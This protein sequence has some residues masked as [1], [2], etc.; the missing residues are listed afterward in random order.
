LAYKPELPE[1]VTLPDGH[2]VDVSHPSYKA[3]E[4][5]A[6]EERWT[7]KSFSRAGRADRPAL[8]GGRSAARLQGLASS[9]KRL[10]PPHPFV[11]A[12][13]ATIVAALA[14]A[15]VLLVV[16]F[17]ANARAAE[18]SGPSP[19]SSAGPGQY[20]VSLSAVTSLSVPEFAVSATICV[21][22]A[23]ARYT[24]DGST[25]TATI[26]IPVAAGQCFAFGGQL[27]SFRI[28]GSGATLDISYYK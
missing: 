20:A 18:M 5:I 14:S 8:P 22:G 6:T 2:R 17:A 21:E 15:V 24:D 12:L 10:Q 26:G 11:E 13:V 28:I 25:P 1:G 9:M 7:Q 27:A 16:A 4:A 3:L 23:A 19:T